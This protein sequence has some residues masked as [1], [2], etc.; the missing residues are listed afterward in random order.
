MMLKTKRNEYRISRL[1]GGR[2]N[3]FLLTNGLGN[4]LIDTSSRFWRPLLFRRLRMSNV[5][6]ITYLFLTH[7][8]YDHADNASAIR[9]KF[10][11]KVIIHELEKQYLENGSAI[12]PRGTNRLT[13]FLTDKFGDRLAA[14]MSCTPCPAD[15]VFSDETTIESNGLAFRIM[16]T[17]GHTCGSSSIIVDEEIALVGDTLFGAFPWSAYPPYSEDAC[18]MVRSWKW[19]L[20][21]RCSLFLPSHGRAIGRKLLE[22]E[23]LKRSS[24]HF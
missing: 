4:V 18:C 14:R 21:T 2:S 10:G 22:K 20:E 1:L 16:P 19:L 8:H 12:V 7:S 15:L 9:E 24:R 5:K 13:R 23:Y 17:P 3:V 6:S 11:A